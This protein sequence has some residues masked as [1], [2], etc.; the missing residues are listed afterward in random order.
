MSGCD[1]VSIPRS[2]RFRMGC[3]KPLTD[4]RL[5]CEK[6]NQKERITVGYVNFNFAC[7]E[8]P[9]NLST[10]RFPTTGLTG[11]GV[12]VG[13]GAGAG[14]E[15]GGRAAPAAPASPGRGSG[16]MA[17]GRRRPPPPHGRSWPGWAA[18][19]PPRRTRGNQRPPR[20]AE[21]S[22]DASVREGE[23]AAVTGGPR[24]PRGGWGAFRL[25]AAPSAFQVMCVWLGAA[26]CPRELLD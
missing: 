7:R 22:G 20:Q 3:A 10:R 5:H 9:F 16:P 6:H 18:P 14:T 15:A 23:A 12:G 26:G 21:R 8:T 25:R 4:V 11:A 24:P 13:A 19:G 17:A 2:Q 1:A